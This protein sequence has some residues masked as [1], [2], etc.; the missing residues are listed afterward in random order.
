[1]C[2]TGCFAKYGSPQLDG[3]LQCSV[4][5]NDC[6]HVPGKENVGWSVD[7]TSDLPSKPLVT[8]NPATMQ[9]VWYKTMGLD[10]RYD[11]FDCQKN[12]FSV[13]GDGILAM[14]ALFRIPRP[15]FPGYLQNSIQEELHLADPEGD[16]HLAH[17]QSQGTMF[18][19]T[20]WEN[21]YVLG[22]TKR[23]VKSAPQTGLISSAYASESYKRKADLKL[24][25][26]TGHTLQGS[27]KGKMLRAAVW[28]GVVWCGVLC[29]ITSITPL[30]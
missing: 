23:D 13:R 25:F 15:T 5:K 24:V 3:L 30:Q 1:M 29:H 18:G 20:F 11:C 27:Y 17:M 16:N 9:G 19:L 21:W 10:S 22:D 4:E 12:T 14:D 28:C 8:F 26:Y 6:V 7:T 2:S